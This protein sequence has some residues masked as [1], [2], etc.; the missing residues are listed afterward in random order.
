MIYWSIIVQCLLE[1]E[2]WFAANLQFLLSCQRLTTVLYKCN[3]TKTGSP[4]I[5]V[6]NAV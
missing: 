2:T 6:L 5:I 1:E 3:K 4:S